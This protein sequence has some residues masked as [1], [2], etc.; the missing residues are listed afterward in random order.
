MVSTM[1]SHG[2]CVVLLFFHTWPPGWLL[3]ALVEVVLLL[4]LRRLLLGR[5]LLSQRLLSQLLL[6]RLFLQLFRPLLGNGGLLLALLVGL[7]T[8]LLL[9]VLLVEL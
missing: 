5:L 8:L 6:S 9:P 7:W 4:L 3:R 2:V 1:R